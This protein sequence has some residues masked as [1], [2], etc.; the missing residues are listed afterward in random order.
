M[1]LVVLRERERDDERHGLRRRLRRLGEPKVASCLGTMIEADTVLTA[2]HCA[3]GFAYWQVTSATGQVAHSSI[4]YT[5]DWADFQSD[6]SHPEHNDVAV[7]KLDT[8]IALGQYPA[9]ATQA[10]PAGSAA[11]RIRPAANG[12]VEGVGLVANDGASVG[13]PHYYYASFDAGETLQTGGALVDPTS[14][15]IYGVVSGRGSATGN[16]YFARA[17]MLASWLAQMATCAP[18]PRRRARGERRLAHDRVPRSRS[19]ARV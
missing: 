12:G 11:M 13:F 14:N 2:G 19:A 15:T 4:A 9:L 17:E 10:L 8:Q 5:Y 7:L 1:R 16:L 6:L 3:A 18:R